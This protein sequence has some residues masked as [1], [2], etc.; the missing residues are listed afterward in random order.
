MMHDIG[1][2]AIPDDILLKEGPLSEAEWEV[3]RLHPENAYR[4]LSEIEYLRPALD[5]PYCHHEHWDGSGYPRGL[6]GEEIPLAARIFAV[7]D[8]WDALLYDRPY[9]KAMSESDVMAYIGKESEKHFD[10]ALVKI[11]IQIMDKS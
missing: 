2:M 5:I 8:V 6:K 10:P 3:M 7:A 4:I 1:K 11:F 9:H